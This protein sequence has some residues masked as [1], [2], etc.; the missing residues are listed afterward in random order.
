MLQFPQADQGEAV[1]PGG[2]AFGYERELDQQG[3][4]E[5]RVHELFLQPKRHLGES[6]HHHVF[7]PGAGRRGRL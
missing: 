5:S 1:P 6:G 7:V 2:R 4:G 3:A